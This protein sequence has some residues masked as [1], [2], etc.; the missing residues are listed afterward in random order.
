MSVPLQNP[1]AAATLLLL[2][3]ATE[4]D[5][6]EDI[7]ARLARSA[8]AVPG[9]DAASC[10]ITTRPGHAPH[11]AASD[12]VAEQLERVQLELK[13]GPCRDAARTRRALNDVPMTHPQSRV[14]WPTFTRRALD[15]GITAVTALPISHRGHLTGSLDLYHQHRSLHPAGAQWGQMLADAAAIGLAHR[16]ELRTARV[17][18]DQLETALTSRILIEQAKGILAERLDCTT[19]AAF[20][21]LRGHA[22]SHQMKLV[23]LS[24]DIITNPHSATPFARR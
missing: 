18:H 5:E 17:R 15:A 20:D 4:G 24:R 13:E 23:D 8:A 16:T 22:R 21:R 11:S 10:A 19:D 7:L 3:D 12:D 2:V 14:R 9:V 6:D 1:P